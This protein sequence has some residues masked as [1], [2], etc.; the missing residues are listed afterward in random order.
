[1]A[2]YDDQEKLREAEEGLKGSDFDKAAK[3]FNDAAGNENKN[4]E[5]ASP[6]RLR[7]AETESNENR[8]IDD[9]LGKGFTG[10]G[11]NND[12]P[13]K[14]GGFRKQFGKITKGLSRKQKIAAWTG[15]I[16]AIV[17][18]FTGGFTF[19][20]ILHI[21]QLDNLMNGI[22]KSGFIRYQVDMDG[23]SNKWIAAYLTLRLAEVE[24]PALK[25]ADRDNILFRSNTIRSD[26][27]ALEWYKLMRGGK[28][29]PGEDYV[30][31][32]EQDLYEKEGIKFVSIACRGTI[33]NNE[34]LPGG[35][36]VR[37]RPAKII[38][39]DG[40]VTFNP[41]EAEIR[42]IENGDVNGFN[43]RLRQFIDVDIMNS[44]KAGRKAIK[45]AVKANT[46]PYQVIKRYYLRKSIQN[47]TGIRDWRFFE[48]TR[49]TLSEKRTSIRNKII[50]KA[51]PESTK[52]G[53]L[54]QCMFGITSCKATT[55]PSDPESKSPVAPLPE[56]CNTSSNPEC[57]TSVVDENGNAQT[58]DNNAA[59]GLTDGV[60]DSDLD[61]S[62][63][64]FTKK[65]LLK[66]LDKLNIATSIVSTIDTLNTINTTVG[67]G[68]LSAMVYMAR[69]Q[70][71]QGMYATAGIMRDQIKT[72][73]VNSQ[74]VNEAMEVFSNAGQSEGWQTVA[75]KG[76][77]SLVSAASEFQTTDRKSVYCSDEHQ[78]EMLLPKNAE[79][80]KGEYHWLCDNEKIGGDN[81]AKSI[82]D[83]WNN[84]IGIILSPILAIYNGSG[85]ATVTGWF[86][87]AIEATLGKV[88]SAATK[89]IL[90]ALGLQDNVNDL[91]AWLTAKAASILGAGPAMSEAAPAGVYANHILM[92][93]SAAAESAARNQGAAETNSFTA[94]ASR[95]NVAAFLGEE[96][97]SMSPFEKYL[98]LSNPKSAA[99]Q[100]LFAV[101]DGGLRKTF[102]STLGSIFSGSIF[103]Q[104]TKAANDDGYAAAKF[105]GV[106]T[107]DFPASCTAPGYKKITETT[108]LNDPARNYDPL[109]ISPQ[110]STNADDLGL[111]PSE[112]LTWDLVTSSD[113]FYAR[114][115][116]GDRS[117][118][119]LKTIKKV[120][121]CALL[122][123]SIRGGLGAL[124]NPKTLGENAYGYGFTGEAGTTS[125][126]GDIP[127]GTTQELAQK[128]LDNNNI[129]FQ[130]MPEQENAMKYIRDTGHARQCGAPNVSPTLLGVIL[131]LAEKYKIVIGVVVDDHGC[132]GGF[133]PKGMA[134][135][136]NGV[137]PLVGSGGTGDHIRWTS[138][139]IN[140]LKSFYNDAGQ[141]LKSAGGGGLGQVNCF[142]NFSIK[143]TTASG[144]SY[145]D[146]TCNHLHMDVGK[147]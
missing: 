83:G 11:S 115:Y 44:D 37:F 145:F 105:S 82:E 144:V 101:L 26:N 135:D 108:L 40:A 59:D 146:D 28:F 25:P 12:S 127:T 33:K 51:L 79:K 76:D 30:T 69:S 10:T 77:S 16:T 61:I 23:R 134:V 116:Q 22:E 75:A 100:G 123:S 90:S 126:V 87:K 86:N 125:N 130:I 41:T 78:E 53:K 2:I 103:A 21:F 3:E 47:M 58:K 94:S 36:V 6:Q 57:K 68:A 5:I 49:D 109:T 17:G 24:D 122:D 48:K 45:E 140:I 112:E 143:P 54:I 118:D 89:N 27:P 137:N 97:Q 80:A 124:Q 18:L 136:L 20:N 31:K 104:K 113:R 71:A 56:D 84:S 81:L 95:Q 85:L 9:K 1:M 13:A 111:I 32:F 19:F 55:D 35:N 72:G 34:C 91:M 141:T 114:L 50:A 121:N 4:K 43:N 15:L 129:S 102:T 66:V 42:A 110:S 70:Q 93:A 73:E 132:D 117:P 128:I 99:S 106:E 98:S 133:H 8:A 65:I 7:A 52:S 60:K 96:Q 63:K 131:A 14:S 120:Y 142:A 39:K 107:Y 92:G 74:E 38:V 64:S 88:I 67:T 139:E 138:S 147:R 29:S 62:T 46:K 119:E